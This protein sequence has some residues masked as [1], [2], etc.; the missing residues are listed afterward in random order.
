M[1]RTSSTLKA[2]LSVLID[3]C[4]EI[5]L[6][7]GQVNVGDLAEKVNLSDRLIRSYLR[8]LQTLGLLQYV[9]AGTYQIDQVLLQEKAKEIT[10]ELRPAK[11]TLDDFL[12]D[13][14]Y[15]TK[16]LE[17]S[18]LKPKVEEVLKRLEYT[19][20]FPEETRTQLR[21]L[22]VEGIPG[23]VGEAVIDRE[24]AR[25]VSLDEVAI[26][27][28]ASVRN[29]NN[30][31]LFDFSYISLAYFC[32]A[33]YTTRFVKELLLSEDRDLVLAPSLET[34][35][36]KEPFIEG[37][38]FY[39]LGTDFP[40][41]LT[42]G[43]TIAARY[44]EKIQ[45]YNLEIEVLKRVPKDETKPVMLIH[46]GS[47][48]PHGFI[49]ESRILRK[50]R[51]RCHDLF[52]QVIKEAQ[53]Q[54]ILLTGISTKPRDDYIYRTVRERAGMDFGRHTDYSLFYHVMRDR[55][56]SCLVSREKERGKPAVEQFYEFYIMSKGE[57]LKAEFVA[58]EDPLEERQKIA[59]FTYTTHEKRPRSE[60]THGPSP[61]IAA[62]DQA[63]LYARSLE[64]LILSTMASYTETLYEKIDRL[65]EEFTRK[66]YLEGEG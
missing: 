44:L 11:V 26:I 41:L 50:L 46:Q 59:N 30:F 33:A 42:A 55:D 1:G 49:V 38:P 51:D 10:S 14:K 7:T 15:I 47:L 57:V 3:A 4:L 2:R 62:L 48:V 37:E 66:K 20:T 13:P 12:E 25:M 29:I 54:E 60:L 52:Y 16:I 32:S 61:M 35:K 28:S 58:L 18:P 21:K 40:E 63:H 19:F 43:R 22:K 36:E 24:R 45:Q 27:G 6:E 64:R 8:M 53:R 39:E 31:K 5:S 34:F 17:T 9:G 65:R 23:F 56:V